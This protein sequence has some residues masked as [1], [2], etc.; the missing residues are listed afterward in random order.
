MLKEKYFKIILL[1]LTENFFFDDKT[2]T[3]NKQI[4]H[5]ICIQFLFYLLSIYNTL[6]NNIFPKQYLNNNYNVLHTI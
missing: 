3:S 6:V 4:I 1:S 5:N 2:F